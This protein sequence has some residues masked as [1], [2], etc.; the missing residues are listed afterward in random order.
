MSN[1]NK[2]TK[3]KLLHKIR[4]NDFAK[5]RGFYGEQFRL[6]SEGSPGSHLPDRKE[7]F[8]FRKARVGHYGNMDGTKTA[9]LLFPICSRRNTGGESQLPIL[10]SG[11]LS[12]GFGTSSWEGCHCCDMA[13]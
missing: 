11:N 2:Q 13:S 5:D 8:T 12:K 10:P 6:V 7:S 4:E 3:T 9:V 1:K